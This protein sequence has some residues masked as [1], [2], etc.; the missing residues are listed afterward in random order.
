MTTVALADRLASFLSGRWP[1]AKRIQG[2]QGG[3]HAFVLSLIAERGKRPLLIVAPGAR[4]AEKLYDDLSFFL[5]ADAATDPFRSRLHL[6]P[7][8]EVLPFENLSPHPENIAGRLEG[9]YKLIEEPAPIVIAS[10]AALM[11]RVIPREALKRSYLYLVAGQELRRDMLLEHLVEWGF[12]NV[13]LVEERGDFSVRGGIVDLFSPG[14]LRPLRLEFDAD[15]LESVREFNPSTQRTERGQEEMLLLP[16]KEFSLRGAGV[17]EALRRL[18]QRAVELE[19]DRRERHRLLES[20][21]AGIPFPGMEFLAPYFSQPLVPA[22]TYLPEQT[23][24]WL[25][26]ADRVEAEAERFGEFAWERQR[27]AQEEHRLVPPAEA[28]YLNEHQW[29]EALAPFSVVRGESLSVMAAS[30][31]AQSA[32]LTVTSYLTSDIRQEAALHG[33]EAS[34]APL[35]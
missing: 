16:M 23:L 34:L 30:E 20:L 29:R 14:Y 26:Q 19:V 15:R 1:G 21:R 10:P 32:T 7:S 33:K 11:Q 3:A 25:D 8:W 2:L 9:L 17:D 12:Q 27:S 6:F 4:D 13:P 35:A 24:I 31:Q 22:F 28:L 5:G 18:D